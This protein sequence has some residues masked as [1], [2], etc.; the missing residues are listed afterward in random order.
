MNK[1][2]RY[3]AMIAWTG[4]RGTGTNNS[5][6]YGRDHDFHMPASR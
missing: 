3:R 1:I 5:D 6:A 4:N 2:H